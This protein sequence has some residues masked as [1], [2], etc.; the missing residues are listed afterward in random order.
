MKK[1]SRTTRDC[2]VPLPIIKNKPAQG[3][4][5]GFGSLADLLHHADGALVGRILASN[6]FR[7]ERDAAQE[8]YFT[9]LSL[10]GLPLGRGRRASQARLEISFRT[11]SIQAHRGLHDRQAPTPSECRVG[12][13]VLVF[14]RWMRN[15][16]QGL[17]GHG[18]VGMRSGLYGIERRGGTD[19]VQGR[20]TGF[21]IAADLPLAE[22]ESRAE[23]LLGP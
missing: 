9:T 19:W 11:G 12:Q 22:L 17:R 21:G 2:L 18:L 4:S 15:L 8:V 23:R 13:R 6:L 1:L 20:G 10:R 16:G 7:M 5:D 3:P 14:H